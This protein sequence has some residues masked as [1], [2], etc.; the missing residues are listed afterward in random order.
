MA[1]ISGTPGR[2]RLQALAKG[3]LL[4][5]LA[6]SDRLSARFSDVILDGGAGDD[7]LFTSIWAPG[8]RTTPALA[9]AEQRGGAGDDRLTLR[10]Q[11]G[12]GADIAEVDLDLA[13]GSGNDLID[14]EITTPEP[15]WRFEFQGKVNGGAGA[16]VIVARLNGLKAFSGPLEVR[17]GTGD[18]TITAEVLTD[19]EVAE[20]SGATRVFGGG[21]DDVIAAT[22]IGAAFD[23]TIAANNHVDAGSGDDLVTAIA[24]ATVA[25]SYAGVAI[26]ALRGGAGNDSLN[27]LLQ[28]GD[29]SVSDLS[30]SLEGGAGDDVMIARYGMGRGHDYHQVDL[31]QELDGGAGD[32]TLAA[33]AR[34]RPRYG[35]VEIVHTLSGGEG[36][37]SLS[38]TIATG[39]GVTRSLLSGGRGA[40]H[41]TVVGGV[42]NVLD[43]GAGADRMIGG[44]GDDQY[45]LDD[46]RDRAWEAANASGGWDVAYAAAGVRG[47]GR[48]MDDLI[49]LG[50]AVEGFGNDGD[51]VIRGN[52]AANQLRGGAGDDTIGGGGGRDLVFG[53]AGEDKLVGGAGDDRLFGGAGD[54]DLRGG[55]GG[56]DLLRGGDGNDR[57]R[58]VGRL[59]EAY[60]EAGDDRLSGD[61]FLYGG[62]GDD[63]LEGSGFMDGGAGEDLLV[64]ERGAGGGAGADTF[65]IDLDAETGIFGET[66]LWDFEQSVDVLAF[67]GIEDLGAPGLVDDLDAISFFTDPA[68]DPEEQGERLK[69]EFDEW[70]SLIFE[71]APNIDSFAELVADPARQLVLADAIL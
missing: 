32:D 13:G 69:I 44:T 36:D 15:I 23:R 63:V 33:S 21:G 17:G 31:R 3:D 29:G 35:L 64:V 4:H 11:V 26:N 48:G 58:V 56:E 38:S 14:L 52:L 67:A 20:G 18:D 1:T 62:A 47:L 28:A 27:S 61:G 10:M 55:G 30:A 70:R 53:G 22:A 8:S 66:E 68:W 60:G 43:G 65:V 5:G 46:A 9:K 12:A 34:G 41:L 24:R 51:N 50:A 42:E 54:D 7:R 49:L 37:D 16:D 25:T 59:G 6:G 39:Y 40:D 45:Y 71:I 19:G 2:D 57:I